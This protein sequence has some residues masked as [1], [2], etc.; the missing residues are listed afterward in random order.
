M[1]PLP[2]AAAT[3]AAAHAWLVASRL[4]IPHLQWALAHMA[5]FTTEV[6]R[7]DP[8][9]FYLGDGSLA[10]LADVAIMHRASGLRLPAHSTSWRSRAVSCATSSCRCMARPAGASARRTRQVRLGGGWWSA[11]V[12]AVLHPR[13]AV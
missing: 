8:A 10:E 9:A 5:P 1:L 12:V 3:A 6:D 11:A 7:T 4:A 13:Q 2:P